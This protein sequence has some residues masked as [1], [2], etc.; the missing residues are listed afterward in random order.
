MAKIIENFEIE[1]LLITREKRLF[2]NVQFIFQGMKRN[3]EEKFRNEKEMGLMNRNR[4]D[5]RR[6]TNN[7]A[8]RLV[9]RIAMTNS[10][11]ASKWQTLTALLANQWLYRILL[12]YTSDLVNSFGTR[13]DI[14]MIV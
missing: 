14:E 7:E 12:D 5:G 1:K 8:A 3:G 11:T 10:G 9:T 6:W 13:F 2:L 4:S